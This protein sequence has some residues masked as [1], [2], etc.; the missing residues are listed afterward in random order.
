MISRG[1]PVCEWTRSLRP[2]RVGW[3]SQDEGV[4]GENC[5]KSGWGSKK[6]RT[7]DERNDGRV[8]KSSWKLVETV[9]PSGRNQLV[10]VG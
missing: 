5:R 10:H 9:L 4:G 2:G 3:P 8:K 1:V 7:S 6:G